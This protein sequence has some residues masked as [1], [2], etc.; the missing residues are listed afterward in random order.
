MNRKH[1]IANTVKGAIAFTILPRNVLGGRG[2]VAPSDRITLGY[3]GTGR[4]ARSL[5]NSL[6][7]CKE[8]IVFAACDVDEKKLD[9]FTGLAEK[10]NEEKVKT[11]VKKY[12]HYQELLERADI[13]A[14]AIATP[15]HWHAQMT[16]DAAKAGKDI[17]CE[18]PLSLK[19]AEGRA[20][21]QAVRKYK[22]V[23]QTGSMQR[24]SFNFRQAAQLVINGYIG[25]IKEINVSV[26]EPSKQCDLPTIKTPDYLDW[27]LWV[28]PALYR[29]YHPTL[30]PP[31]EENV[32]AGWRFY[33][34]FGGGFVTD[35]G[36]HMFDIVQWALGMDNSGPVKFIPPEKPGAVNGLSL[37]YANGVVVNHKPWG[38][39]NA[40]QFI[41]E[42]GKIEVSRGFL[43]TMPAHLAKMKDFKPTDKRLYLSDNHHQ[44]WINA[45]KKRSKPVADVEI[46]HRSATVCNAINIAYELQRKLKWDPVN[47]KL[48]DG[49]ANMMLSRPYRNKWNFKNF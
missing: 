23:C 9:L 48:D 3:I 12:K 15:D 27:D 13:D 10:A 25:R 8:T 16:V 2:F 29:G 19:I 7:S 28:G 41:G 46:G 42:Y 45:I 47:E 18:K 44:D 37:A 39:N 21:V 36:A 4:M 20:M 31:I 43:R 11:A 6:N 22:R 14:V 32:W 33:R 30:S 34:D 40:I 5:L 49:Y 38:E 35:W 26:G 24:S 17:Y 1:F